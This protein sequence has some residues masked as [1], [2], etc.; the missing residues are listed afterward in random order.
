MTSVSALELRCQVC[1]EKDGFAPYIPFNETE[2]D[3][4]ARR[5]HGAAAP[6]AI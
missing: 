4:F 6:L 1:G 3:A 5:G 2:V